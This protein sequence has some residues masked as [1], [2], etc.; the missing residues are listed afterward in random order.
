MITPIRC[1][2]DT[3]EAT[4]SGDLEFW[5]GKE[6]SRRKRTAQL[7][8]TP[9]PIRLCNENL[10]VGDRGMR[11]YDYVVRNRDLMLLFSVG[12]AMPPMGLRLFAEGL[13]SRGVTELWSKAKEIAKEVEVSPLNLTR[14]DVAV[15]F[16]SWNPSFEEMQHVVC[17]SSFRPVYPNTKAPETFQFGKGA[18]VLRLYDKTKEIAVKDKLWWHNVWRL[19]GY[20]PSLPVWRLE[21]QL[22]SAALK[23]LGCRDVDTALND[24][25][26]L[27]CYGLDWC[28]LRAS[29]NDTNLRR[30][31]E[32]PAWIDLRE[33]FAPARSLGRIR[34]VVSTMSYDAAVGRIAGLLATAAAV[35]GV[36]DYD[37]LVQD[38][39]ADVQKFVHDRR[40]MSFDELVDEKR[41]RFLSGSQ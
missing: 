19:L 34:P 41:R 21:V 39:A 31:T 5:V 40:E 12:G 16:Q 25:Y 32:H 9:E 26:A 13:A 1:G 4:F 20:D 17:K 28:S 7:A 36:T 37:A 22:R 3:L 24:I 10:F 29:S 14:I 27:F 8:N 6:L 38:V 18:V 11:F 23:E 33:K 15:D 35:T 2:V 30:A